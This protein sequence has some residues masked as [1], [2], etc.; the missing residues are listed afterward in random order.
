MSGPRPLSSGCAFTNAASQ[1]VGRL[2][3]TGLRFLVILIIVKHA[4]VSAFGEYALIL[5]VLLCAE[6][7]VD[8]G[9]TDVAVRGLAQA[10]ERAARIFGGLLRA[11]LLLSVLAAIGLLAI[12]LLLDYPP[13]ILAAGAAAVPAVLAHAGVLVF[14]ATLKANLRM[15]LEVL[16]E[17]AATLLVIPLFW[18]VSRHG[19]GPLELIACYSLLRLGVLL[20][21]FCIARKWLRAGFRGGGAGEAW[22]LGRQSYPVGVALLVVCSYDAL[23]PILL[24][25]LHDAEQ[26]GWFAGSMRFMTLLTMTLHPVADT[27]LPLLAAG[28]RESQARFRAILERTFRM[29][30]FLAGGGFCVYLASTA[31][32]LGLMGPEMAGAA[33]TFQLLCWVAL[34]R[35]MMAIMSPLIIVTGGMRQALGITVL[36]IVLKIALLLLLVP[37]HGAPGAAIA[38]MAGEITSIVLASLLVRRL[39]GFSLQWGILLRILPAVGGALLLCWI[40]GVWGTWW[41]GFLAGSSYVGLAA[42]AG[43]LPRDEISAMWRRAVQPLRPAVSTP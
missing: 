25:K 14:R 35:S 21:L 5:T 20:S 8:F 40:A 10:P 3:L 23:D 36:G 16:A 7:L 18:I 22:S 9:M 31:A 37:S 27:A 11:K 17:L 19:A 24:S 42:L 41:G 28:W 4:G 1:M 29:L 32:L 30:A 13:R 2:M 39:M 12:L 38:N 33:S 15:D 26:V 34:G 43:A 6:V